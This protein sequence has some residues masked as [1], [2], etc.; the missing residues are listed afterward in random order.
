MNREATILVVEDEPGISRLV[1]YHLQR[2]GFAVDFAE[3]G[4]EALQKIRQ[5]EYC[6]IVLDIMLPGLDGFELCR[7]IKS[8]PKVSHLPIIMLTAKDDEVDKVVGLELGADDYVTKPFSPRE[9]MARVKAVLRRVYGDRKPQEQ[10]LKIG[11]FVLEPERF[12]L[13]KSGREI[14]L[15]AKEFRL[16]Y[17]LAS[18]PGRVFS[19]HRLLDEVWG[20]DTFVEPRTV[21]V[22]IRRLREKLEDNPSRP[23]FLKTKRAAG[24]YF[25]ED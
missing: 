3:T 19:R 18:N 25:S 17:L 8:D 14:E 15:S 2:E 1:G 10:V 5:G 16:L 20:E 4:T 22:H 23:R 12:R 21:D 6:L 7:L 24:Y 11:P 13:L 9:L